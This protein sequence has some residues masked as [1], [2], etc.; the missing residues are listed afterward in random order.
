MGMDRIDPERLKG[1]NK[2]FDDFQKDE[3]GAVRPPQTQKSNILHAAMVSAAM[4]GSI[5]SMGGK[6]EDP[7]P[8]G[9]EMQEKQQ[10]TEL[11]REIEYG[12]TPVHNF[13]LKD[14]PEAERPS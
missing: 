11:F 7:R 3:S 10:L 6:K 12:A 5:I 9:I 4:A 13:E 2:L 14:F 8:A 1:A